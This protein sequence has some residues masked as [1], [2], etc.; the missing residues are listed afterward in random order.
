ME[1]KIGNSTV[2]VTPWGVSGKSIYLKVVVRTPQGEEGEEVVEYHNPPLTQPYVL[3]MGRAAKLLSPKGMYKLAFGEKAKAELEEEIASFK[4]DLLRQGLQVIKGPVT[5]RRV[6]SQYKSIVFLSPDEPRSALS[7]VQATF[8]PFFAVLASHPEVLEG[9]EGVE[10]CEPVY[11]DYSYYQDIHF[12]PSALHALIKR[13]EEA[14]VRE[15]REAIDN[16]ATMSAAEAVRTWWVKKIHVNE[17]GEFS[18]CPPYCD[19]CVWVEVW[20]AAP[21]EIKDSAPYYSVRGRHGKVYFYRRV[22]EKSFQLALH[23]PELERWRADTIAALQ[24]ELKRYEALLGLL[25]E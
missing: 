23:H 10:I 15:L 19:D 22:D 1:R 2:I 12:A 9:K 18:D 17:D 8:A 3:L 7:V 14:K 20:G 21:K 16:V 13:V 6:V 24:A 25:E 11:D 5:L 4:A